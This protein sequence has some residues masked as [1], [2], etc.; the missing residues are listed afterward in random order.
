MLGVEDYMTATL[1]R[2]LFDLTSL[3]HKDKKRLVVLGGDFIASTQWDKRYSNSDPSHKLVFDRLEDFGLVNCTLKYFKSHVQTSR[4]I[5]SDFP[6]QIDYI[7]A[8]EKLT[9]NIISCYV[10]ED[11][12]IWELS[13][14]N[15]LGVVF[16]L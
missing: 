16:E 4:P 6:W 1:H 14:H 8:S 10:K 2:V 11:P 3:L 12:V 5:R 9:N 13:D 15:P 7:F